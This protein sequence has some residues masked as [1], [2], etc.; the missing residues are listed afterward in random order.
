MPE[1]ILI[2]YTPYEA[3][4]ALIEHKQLQEIYIERSNHHGI[5]GNIYK[6]KVSRIAPGMQAAFLDIGLERSAFLHL[7]DTLEFI[8]NTNSED[9]KN[10]EISQMFKPGQEVLVQVYKDT[11]GSKGARL[12]TQFGIPSRYLVFTPGLFQINV[13][14]K[15]INPAARERLQNLLKPT[16]LG[17]YIFRTV[18]EQASSEDILADQVFLHTLWEEVLMWAKQAKAG[19]MVYQE[20]PIEMRVLR[21]FASPHTKKVR[22]DDQQIALNMR[23]F[24][25]KNMRGQD[26]EKCIEYYAEKD[27]IFD[28]YGIEQE[29][30]RL[31][32]RRVALKSGGY[33]V[34]DQTEAMTT[35]DVNTGSFLGKTHSDQTV[36]QTNLE[37]VDA[38]ARQVRLRNLG[39]IIIIDFIDMEEHQ[40]RE[41]VINHLTSTVARDTA[42][43][44]VSEMSNLGLVQMTRKRTRESLEHVLCDPCPTCQK[45]GSIKS[46]ETIC[47]EIM[48]EIDKSSNIY[49]WPGFLVKASPFVVQ[50]LQM[51]AI[52][53]VTSIGK[54]LRKEINFHPEPSYGQE[55]YDVEPLG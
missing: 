45:R 49:E 14:Q 4:V 28:L 24:A 31:L 26:L 9:K 16:A 27:S 25:A 21:D 47:Y 10:L 13:S 43:V 11:L 34:I 1:E 7:T 39:G 22:V 53:H 20:L 2:N 51:Y 55:E 48:R 23:E 38:I 40:H 30:Q 50:Y 37:A 19:Q 8:N 35:I 12:T 3:R 54:K 46:V 33:I 41:K 15:I 29:I 17:G 52:D 6:G 44:E 42:R 36:L 32:E 5:L 18:A